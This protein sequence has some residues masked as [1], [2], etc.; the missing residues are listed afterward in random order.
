MRTDLFISKR[1]H[2]GFCKRDGTYSGKLAYVTYEDNKGKMRKEVSWNNWRDKNIPVEVYDNEPLA[3]YV[4]HKSINQYAYWTG[5]RTAVRIYDP[6]GFEFEIS[7]NNLV[8]L[9]SHANLI[10][11]EIQEKCIFAQMGADLVLLS[12][13]SEIYKEAVSYTE[14]QDDKVAA[15]D[16]KPGYIYLKRKGEDNQYIYIGYYD[17]YVWEEDKEY[18]EDQ[19]R[20]RYYNNYMYVHA[21]KKKR[22]V[23]INVNIVDKDDTRWRRAFQWPSVSTFAQCIS[24]EP[25]ENFEKIRDSFLKSDQHQPIVDIKLQQVDFI[26]AENNWKSNQYAFPTQQDHIIRQ[27]RNFFHHRNDDS[28]IINVT[29]EHVYTFSALSVSVLHRSID[30]EEMK[31]DASKKAVYKLVYVL[32]DGTEIKGYY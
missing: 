17:T 2:V 24:D 18:R 19:R 29:I 20:H 5:K 11:G 10:D 26:S 28:N 14:R 16:L 7:L 4:I 15:K 8:S 21:H 27:G 30:S 31:V 9:I 23:F 22:H 12:T 25:V 1:I 3:G 32:E 6:R 13:N